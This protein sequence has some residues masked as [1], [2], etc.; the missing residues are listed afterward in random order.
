MYVL[1]TNY[2]SQCVILQQ[3]KI[4]KLY[5]GLLNQKLEVKKEAIV[6][7]KIP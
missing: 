1:L 6:E 7:E 4:S 2:F 5:L 3:F